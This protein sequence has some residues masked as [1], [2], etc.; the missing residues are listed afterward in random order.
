MQGFIKTS[1]ISTNT[2]PFASSPIMTVGV[3]VSNEGV[4]ADTG[5]KK[6]VKA[7]TPVYGDIYDR[8]KPFKV[9][10]TTPEQGLS[11][12][13]SIESPAGVLLTDVNVT[14][15]NDNGTMV[16]FG[17]INTDNLDSDVAALITDDIKTAL[18][19]KVTFLNNK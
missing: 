7:G 18:D 13:S 17:F 6:V 2:I 15:G 14:S 11:E 12:T 9:K 4:T 5:G 8:S 1:G 3:I 16:I 10:T 19:G